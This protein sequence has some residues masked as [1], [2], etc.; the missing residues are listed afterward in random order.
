MLVSTNIYRLAGVMIL[1]IVDCSQTPQAVAAKEQMDNDIIKQTTAY[2]ND[3]IVYREPGSSWYL[4]DG[5]ITAMDQMITN[6]E[7][8]VGLK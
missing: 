2:Q 3:Q 6:I 8:G 1:L 5:G 4:C 7:E